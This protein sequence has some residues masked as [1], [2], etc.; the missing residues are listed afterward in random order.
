MAESRSFGR[1]IHYSSKLNEKGNPIT[2][3]F[4]LV[5]HLNMVIKSLQSLGHT[6]ENRYLIK[7]KKE[8]RCK[9]SKDQQKNSFI[10][11]V[12]VIFIKN[13]NFT[14]VLSPMSI[15]FNCYLCSSCKGY[16]YVFH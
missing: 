3:M 12:N 7:L 8:C 16:T 15:T 10:L 6:C 9:M 5:R 4:L 2:L 14:G 1:D 13:A 11:L